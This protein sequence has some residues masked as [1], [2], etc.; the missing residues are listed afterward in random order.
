MFARLQRAGLRNPDV[1]SGKE[2][3]IAVV[4]DDPSVRKALERVLRAEGHTVE[5]HASGVELLRSLPRSTPHCIV[6]DLHM[7]GLD[8]FEVQA[9]LVRGG[10]RIPVIMI[11]GHYDD[12]ACSRAKALGA[13]AVLPKPVDSPALLH[14]IAACAQAGGAPER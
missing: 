13:K 1:N 7:P 8:G 3:L 11:T 2:S 9:A 6:L 4:D 14:E 5:C 10:W 12:A